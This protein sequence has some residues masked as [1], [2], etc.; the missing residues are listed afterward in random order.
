MPGLQPVIHHPM[1]PGFPEIL[2]FR[3]VRAGEQQGLY[4][5]RARWAISDLRF[6]QLRSPF[7]RQRTFSRAR[8]MSEMLRALP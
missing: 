7:G 8:R 6:A 2:I 1:P 5:E 4:T 3:Y